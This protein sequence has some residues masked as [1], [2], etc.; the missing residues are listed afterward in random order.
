MYAQA[1]VVQ[2][3]RKKAAQNPKPA[4]PPATEAGA[5]EGAIS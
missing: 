2:K 4:A 1:A 5:D 3:Q